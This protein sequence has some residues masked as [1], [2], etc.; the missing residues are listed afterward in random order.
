[1][2]KG[3]GRPNT[4]TT[5]RSQVSASC[6]LF[7][8]RDGRDRDMLHR[9]CNWAA[10]LLQSCCSGANTTKIAGYQLLQAP[11]STRGH[12]SGV[13]TW[14]GVWD[15]QAGSPATPQL[16]PSTAPSL[17]PPYSR[18]FASAASRLS[19]S[20]SAAM[21]VLPLIL[22]RLRACRR[23]LDSYVAHDGRY[24]RISFVVHSSDARSAES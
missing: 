9:S 17:A 16:P 4:A 1:M 20:A 12:V 6:A 7:A 23:R 8:A 10:P 21:L 22:E 18:P 13:G 24:I 2:H 3:T 15:G 11:T 14:D 19:A 5:P